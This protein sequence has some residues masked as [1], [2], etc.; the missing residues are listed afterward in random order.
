MHVLLDGRVAG[1]DGIGRY[2]RCLSAALERRGD[3]RL[4]V[5]APTG[6]APYSRAFGEELVAAARSIRADLVHVVDFR[7]PLSEMP[8]PAVVSIHDILR[9]VVPEH[10]YTDEAFAERFGPGGLAEL[11]EATEVLRGL[12]VAIPPFR[13]RVPHSIHEEFYA[14]MVSLAVRRAEVVIAPTEVVRSQIREWLVP[15]SRIVAAAYGVDHVTDSLVSDT[16]LPSG[17]FLLYVGQLRPHKGVPILLE[18]FARSHARRRGVRLVLVGPDFEPEGPGMAAVSAK[19]LQED[20]VLLGA[21]SDTQLSALYRKAQAVA[22]LATHEGFGFTPLEAM[23]H[24]TPVIVSDIPV[25][26]ET[27]RDFATYVP[28]DRPS[29]VSAVIDATVMATDDEAAAARR[30]L[31]A[32]RYTWARHAEAVWASYTSVLHG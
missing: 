32:G 29:I 4:T 10:C 11:I 7:V 14:R 31:W 19:D 16:H 21:V 12:K 27:L 13:A 2:T 15:S 23:S 3:I 22:H 1:A 20:T 26:R 18:A 17:P 25:F 9:L 24:G 28:H 6:T 30:R 5:L 8:Y